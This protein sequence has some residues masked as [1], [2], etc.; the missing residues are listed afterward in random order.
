MWIAIS[1]GAVVVVAALLVTGL[2]VPGWMLGSAGPKE[3]AQK[4][5][6]A[7]NNQDADTITNDLVCEG[8]DGSSDFSKLRKK[9]ITI[10]LS[11]TGDPKIDGD[12]ATQKMKFEAHK[13][14]KGT[15]SANMDLK[16]KNEDGG[17]C[18]DGADMDRGSLQQDPEG[19]SSPSDGIDS[20]SSRTREPTS[21]G[22]SSSSGES[23]SVAEDFVGAI[24]DKDADGAKEALCGHASSS[25]KSKVDK[26]TSKGTQ[27]EFASADGAGNSSMQS[28]KIEPKEGEGNGVVMVSKELDTKEPCVYSLILYMH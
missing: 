11:V 27:L 10:K 2:A 7:I 18:A 24:N 1:A 26:I 3:V 16:L 9:N 4:F 14:G 17:W 22:G 12:T 6:T 5:A 23:K 15:V 19:A 13:A 8:H 20:D 28:Y 21:S 25:T